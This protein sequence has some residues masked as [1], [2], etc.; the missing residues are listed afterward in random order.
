ME[1]PLVI[2]LLTCMRSYRAEVVKALQ[3]NETW[4]E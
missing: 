1:M 4:I 2:S 3:G